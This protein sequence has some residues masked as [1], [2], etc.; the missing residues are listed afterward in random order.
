MESLSQT[1][2]SHSPLQTPG[3]TKR[4]LSVAEIASQLA[5][6]LLTYNLSLSDMQLKQVAS[7]LQLMLAK[8]ERVNL[9]SIRD[10]RDAL[11]LHSL[12]SLLFAKVI[13]NHLDLCDP[14][15]AGLDMGT[16]GG[17]PGIALACVSDLQMTLLDSVGKK[18]S[19]CQEF[20]DILG[21]DNQVSCVHSRLEDFA[22]EQYE[23][24][25]FVT[26][27]ALASLDIL[28]EYGA[29]FV[30]QG[31]YFFFGKA[32]PTKE[33]LAASKKVAKMLGIILVSRETFELPNEYGHREIFV[34]QK[35]NPSRIKLPRKNGE[36]RKNPLAQR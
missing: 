34:Y 27:R 23:S 21:I 2:E 32:N 22:L 14:S 15:M 6:E 8:N 18:V 20:V 17:F 12:D 11:V 4:S 26:A 36:A 13:S 19:A 29:P 1:T 5:S 25:D 3:D 33:E 35:V 31:G 24:F 16:G 10:Q 30:P 7:H 28:L 9:T